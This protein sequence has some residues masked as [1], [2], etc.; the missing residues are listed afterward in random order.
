MKSIME[1]IGS[2]KATK[3]TQE[4]DFEL[5]EKPSQDDDYLSPNLKDLEPIPQISTEYEIKTTEPSQEPDT[6]HVISKLHDAAVA[7]EKAADE[8]ID[9]AIN[10]EVAHTISKHA[11]EASAYA[12]D[13]LAQGAERAGKTA[14]TTLYGLW[15]AI[16]EHAAEDEEIVQVTIDEEIAAAKIIKDEAAIVAKITEPKNNMA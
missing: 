16:S 3:E 7:I 10:S 9:E 15:S 4:H 14:L 2:Q 6:P 5:I 13:K 11:W 1:L 12:A 8:F